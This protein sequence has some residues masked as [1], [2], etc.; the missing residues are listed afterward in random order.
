MPKARRSPRRRHAAPSA[1]PSVNESVTMPLVVAKFL[2][3]ELPA[4]AK[5]YL[6]AVCNECAWLPQ[7]EY[8]ELLR[9]KLSGPLPSRRGRPRKPFEMPW[10]WVVYD[11]LKTTYEKAGRDAGKVRLVLQ[12][13]KEQQGP[14][15]IL[16]PAK[17]DE[18][19]P[20]FFDEPLKMDLLLEQDLEGIAKGR[21]SPRNF[22]LD[23]LAHALGLGGFKGTRERILKQIKRAKQ[24]WRAGKPSS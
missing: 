12:W 19:F 3:R 17:L 22:A 16:N 2:W 7:R 15:E 20:Q 9:R 21:P 11:V 8:L 13:M 4:E 18:G 14:L 24:S 6:Q 23:V 5:K 1:R 10:I